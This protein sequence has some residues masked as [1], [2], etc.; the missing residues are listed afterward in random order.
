MNEFDIINE[1]F[2]PLTMGRAEAGGLRDDAAILS[3]P[4]GHELIVSTDTL[5]A[6]VHFMDGAAPADIAHK[7]LR[8]NLSDLAAMGAR[9]L[10]YQLALGLP[11]KPTPEWLLSFTG[12]LLADQKAFGIFCSGGDTTSIHGKLSISITAMGLVERGRTLKRSGAQDG[13]AIV[14][15]GPIGDAWVG[16]R[17]LQGKIKTDD[18]AYFI[19]RYYRPTPRFMS[20]VQNIKAAIDV[21]DGGMADLGH[22]CRASKV[23][24]RIDLSKILFSAPAQIL[25][26]GG[27]V[28]P[29]DL[30]TGGDDYEL[31]MA[32]PPQH[33]HQYGTVIG[34]FKTG[35]PQV[36]IVDDAG[37]ALV[38]DKA[39]WTHF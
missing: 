5:N 11:E 18:N 23:S 37:K 4:A 36:Y 31:I 38:F 21:S 19:D 15:T 13:D 17:V 9:P 8:S 39:G 16:L 29:Q 6:D 28:T 22:M 33:A 2:L 3:V 35:T 34:A 14:L 1:Y 24:A 30:L 20:D 32:V 27:L 12:A 26:N 10:C 25:L 7:A